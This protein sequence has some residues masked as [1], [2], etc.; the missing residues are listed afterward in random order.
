MTQNFSIGVHSG[1]HRCERAFEQLRN[2][3]FRGSLGQTM[4]EDKRRYPRERKR[5]KV[6]MGG[7]PL[8]TVDLSSGGFCVELLR[9]LKPGS[10]VGGTITYHGQTFDFS[11]HVAW[12]KEGDI[13][14]G[15]RGRMGVEFSAISPDFFTLVKSIR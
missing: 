12:A 15:L 10:P 1:A 3:R 6:V 8:F 2:T 7:T 5:A 9:V 13:R 4:G 11:G 14:L